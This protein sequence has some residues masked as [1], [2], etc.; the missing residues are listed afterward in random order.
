PLFTYVNAARAATGGVNGS[1]VL[2]VDSASID[3]SAQW[4]PL[5]QDS[6]AC[7][8]DEPFLCDASRG[9]RALPLR[10]TGALHAGLRLSP[11][12][13]LELYGRADLLSERVVDE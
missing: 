10:P 5:A 2:S 6:S 3:V 11:H 9:A 4:L 1:V 12:D 7:P 8:A 13:S